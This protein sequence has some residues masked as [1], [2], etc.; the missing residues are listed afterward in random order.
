MPDLQFTIER[1]LVHDALHERG[2]SLTV[3]AH[4][5]HLFATLDGQVYMVEDQMRGKRWVLGGERILLS[6]VVANHGIVARTEAGREFQVHGA[7]VHLVNLD[8]HH[9]L[10]LFDFL[11]HLHSLC[12]LIAE[13]LDEGPHV[14]HL[15]LLVLVGTYL[16]FASLCAELHVF[17]VFYFVV[18]YLSATDFQCAIGDIVDKS[19]VVAHQYYGFSALHQELLQPLYAVDVQMVGGLVEEQHIGLLKQ[20]LGQFDTH[21]PATTELARR[22][23]EVRS[24]ESQAAQGALH[25]RLVV[26]GSQQHVALVLFRVALHEL[27]VVVAFVV[28]PFAELLV[29]TVDSLLEQRLVGERLACLFA[30]GGVV[31]EVHHLWQIAYDDVFWQ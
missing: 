12:G 26:L 8:G 2:L 4:E 27:H 14:G 3:L 5:G 1:Y 25:F 16:L 17:V 13:T 11:L 31:G 22:P 9:F 30:H 6:D 15:L 18:Y 20:Y 10:Q 7:I 19:P 23:V 28:G 29:H 21:A 24:Q